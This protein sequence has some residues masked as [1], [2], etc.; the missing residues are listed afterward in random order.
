[1]TNIYITSP[2][3][4]NFKHLIDFKDLAD[5]KQLI[6]NFINFNMASYWDAE[7]TGFKVYTGMPIYIA[8]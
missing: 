4:S 7:S 8:V 6:G 3:V 1:V 2:P 5:N